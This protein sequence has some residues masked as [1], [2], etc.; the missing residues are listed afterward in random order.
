[1]DLSTIPPHEPRFRCG[2]RVEYT[3]KDGTVIQ[4]TVSRVY[5][6][7]Q[8]EFGV[9]RQL[10]YSPQLIHANTAYRLD[11]SYEDQERIGH[12][13]TVAEDRLRTLE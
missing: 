10:F 4:G 6:R 5:R 2:E 11:L 9:E 13:V 7:G 12:P 1:M 8:S 3:R